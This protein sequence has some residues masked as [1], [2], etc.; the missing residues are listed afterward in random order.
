[1]D[2]LKKG[3]SKLITSLY[4]VT[5]IPIE[6]TNVVD[7]ILLTSDKARI[8]DYENDLPS[9]DTHYY[10]INCFNSFSIKKIRDGNYY[11]TWMTFS[12]LG[13]HISFINE[14]DEFMKDKIIS[15]NLPDKQYVI[16]KCKPIKPKQKIAVDRVLEIFSKNPKTV[17]YLCGDI[18]KEKSGSIPMFLLKELQKKSNKNYT[19]IQ[20]FNPLIS[21]RYEDIKLVSII[22]S[23]HDE[24]SI[25]IYSSI[26][27]IEEYSET[28]YYS[29]LNND[30][31]DLFLQ[32]D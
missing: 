15:Y 2:F 11:Q 32:I 28:T 7:Y 16:L 13:S 30:K 1:M 14:I 29:T 26:S 5:D 10:G 8:V 3:Y 22:T 31:I 18:S 17:I 20:N 9:F 6:Y 25:I 12:Q 4:Q 19:L 21:S 24:E 23:E 27:C